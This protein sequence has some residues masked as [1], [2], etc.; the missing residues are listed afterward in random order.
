MFQKW[1]CYADKI[2]KYFIIKWNLQKIKFNNAFIVIG[3]AIFTDVEYLTFLRYIYI[4]KL[5]DKDIPFV[6]AFLR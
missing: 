3:V 6:N 4:I 2:I 1:R 5:Q